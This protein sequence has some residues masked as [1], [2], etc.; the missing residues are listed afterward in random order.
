MLFNYSDVDD[1]N[2]FLF[3][4]NCVPLYSQLISN[5]LII[6]LTNGKTDSDMF[7]TCDG[8]YRQSPGTKLE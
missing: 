5:Q 4:K 1:V 3:L 2:Q 6:V 8:I 7:D